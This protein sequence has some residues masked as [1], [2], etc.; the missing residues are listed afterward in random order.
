MQIT[1]DLKHYGLPLFVEYE[2]INDDIEFDIDWWTVSELKKLFGI[3]L[4]EKEKKTRIQAFKFGQGY[5][6][7]A[8]VYSR[9]DVLNRRLIDSDGA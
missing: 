5:R 3:T 1:D 4:T 8:A 9:E 2:C 7:W 6:Q